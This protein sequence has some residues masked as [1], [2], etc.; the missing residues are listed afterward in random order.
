MAKKWYAYLFRENIY[1]FSVQAVSFVAGILSTVIFPNLLGKDGFGYFSIVIGVASI[2][3]FFCDIGIPAALLKFIPAGLKEGVAWKYYELLFSWKLLASSATALAAFLLAD[4]IAGAYGLPGLADGLRLGAA[5][6]LPYAMLPFFEN[7][8]IGLKKARTTFVMDCA[9]HVGRI[10]LPLLL[11]LAVG[12]GYLAAVAGNLIGCG[13]AVAIGWFLASREPL[14]KRSANA[15]IDS[16]ALKGYVV[17]GVIWMI[18]LALIQW[19]DLLIIGLFRPVSDVSVYRVA[20]LWATATAFLFPFSQKIFFAAHAHE[21]DARSRAV[22]SLTLKYG[23]A[24]A[25]L[26]I[27]GIALVAAQFLS[28]LYSGAYDEAY[29]VMIVL[30]M[31]TIDITLSTLASGLL[32]GK[33]DIRTPTAIHAVAGVAQVVLLFAVIPAF[34][35]LGAAAVVVLVRVAAA[36]AQTGFA[37]RFLSLRI[38]ASY[39][40]M[41][42]LCA[43][44]TAL[45][46]LPLREYTFSF[47]LALAYGTMLVALYGLLATLLRV[48]DLREIGAVVRGSV[49]R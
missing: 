48:V 43:I 9:F 39:V 38:P 17:F 3:T 37:L 30:S 41:P 33:G 10:A 21:D 4:A 28:L 40:Y 7:A 45:L 18:A 44:I 2:G 36:I 5:F 47:P 22:F 13:I 6:L 12:V 15:V 11:F 16:R 27:A 1:G 23:L 31:L 34:G 35:M 8:F 32:T 49:A 26:M 20:W 42:A 14:L 24:F 46:L 19:S 29:P 25:F